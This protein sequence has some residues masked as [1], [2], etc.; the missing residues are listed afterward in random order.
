MLKRSAVNPAHSTYDLDTH[1]DSGRLLTEGI[2]MPTH[3]LSAKNAE[4]EEKRWGEECSSKHSVACGCR[5]SI[6]F[7]FWWYFSKLKTL[8]WRAFSGALGTCWRNFFEILGNIYCREY[9][10]GPVMLKCLSKS[11]LSRLSGWDQQGSFRFLTTVL[12]TLKD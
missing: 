9:H 7:G 2:V 12:S 4:E 10:V 1:L 5:H 3:H 11:S 6:C 8:T